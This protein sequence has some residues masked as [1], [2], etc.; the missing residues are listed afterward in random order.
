MVVSVLVERRRLLRLA[1][2]LQL[3]AQSTP[4]LASALGFAASLAPVL[5]QAALALRRVAQHAVVLD[6]VVERV[7]AEPVANQL[8]VALATLEWD[9]P[10]V[11]LDSL[12]QSPA[13]GVALAVPV[14][15]GPAS[16][17]V[18]DLG[19]VVVALVPVD[20]QS[21]TTWTV[22][23]RCSEQAGF[24]VGHGARS[25]CWTMVPSPL[26]QS[27]VASLAAMVALALARDLG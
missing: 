5:R 9:L 16:L 7:M 25:L 17:L 18:R 3:V 27:M 23:M 24:A 8:V 4:A 10:P 14:A 11:V 12:D 19:Q 22:S 2:V 15:L 26:D 1:L 13:G 6:L 20:Q 21:P